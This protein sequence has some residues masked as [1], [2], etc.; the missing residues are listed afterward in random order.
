MLAKYAKAI[1]A[2]VGAAIPAFIAAYADR[3]I[4]G[5]DWLAILLALLGTPAAV[6]AIPNRQASR[7]KPST[8]D[9]PVVG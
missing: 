9:G 1:T 4:G 2:L 8:Y 6:A 7:V 5:A 3:S